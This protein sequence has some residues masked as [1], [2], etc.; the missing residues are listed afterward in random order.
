[1]SDEE[2]VTGSL[3][4]PVATRPQ[5]RMTLPPQPA[6]PPPRPPIAAT[7]SQKRPAVVEERLPPPPQAAEDD[8][9]FS[10]IIDNLGD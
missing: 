9:D 4:I 6:P 10:S 8:A 3:P 7:P 2:A 1:L 5:P